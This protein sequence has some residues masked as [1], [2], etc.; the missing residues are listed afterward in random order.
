MCKFCLFSTITSNGYV[1]VN[2]WAELNFQWAWYPRFYLQGMHYVF[3]RL[4]F[5][6]L[7]PSVDARHRRPNSTWDLST[8]LFHSQKSNPRSSNAPRKLVV[9]MHIVAYNYFQRKK[10]GWIASALPV[11]AKSS[12]CLSY[13]M[14]H[15]S[16]SIRTSTTIS[17][18]HLQHCAV[19]STL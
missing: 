9:E 14:F 18:L 6:I 12:M 19:N 8:E 2:R 17:V 7:T 15:W 4:L 11:I 3:S 16:V 5:I 1:I 13:S 10:S